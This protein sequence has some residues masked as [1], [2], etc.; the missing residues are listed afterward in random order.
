MFQPGT[1]VA[2]KDTQNL[3]GTIAGGC[4]A[5]IHGLTHFL[6]ILELD[7]ECEGWMAGL[8]AYLTTL[9]VSGDNLIVLED[10]QK[11]V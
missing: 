3:R 10:E 8:E 11:S 1:R 4:F 6:Y 5:T 7:V 9:V 2:V